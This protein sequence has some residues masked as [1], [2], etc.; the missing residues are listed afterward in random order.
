MVFVV[1]FY[2]WMLLD[3]ILKNGVVF[4]GCKSFGWK[5]KLN[6]KIFLVLDV[7]FELSGEKV[8]ILMVR[9]ELWGEKRR[10]RSKKNK[11]KSEK[12]K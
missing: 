5:F 12:R 8:K 7:L 2:S 9:K 10:E 4:I 11:E 6:R 1:E 3:F